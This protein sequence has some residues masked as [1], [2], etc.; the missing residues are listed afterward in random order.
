MTTRKNLINPSNGDLEGK[1]RNLQSQLAV[2]VEALE[3]IAN[4]K[5]TSVDKGYLLIQCEGYKMAGRGMNE[6]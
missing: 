1:I 6:I 4:H 3:N 2:A 5:M